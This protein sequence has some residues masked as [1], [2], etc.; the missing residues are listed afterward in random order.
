MTI[1]GRLAE[2]LSAYA[3]TT[4]ERSVFRCTGKTANPLAPSNNGGRWAPQQ[5]DV[6]VLY[7]SLMSDGAVAEK[8]AFLLEFTPP[9]RGATLRIATIHVTLRKVV[10]LADDDLVKFGVDPE[11]FGTRDYT[12]TKEIGAAVKF[13]GCDGLIA[14][15]ARWSC[16]N[17][18]VYT[19]NLA[20]YDALKLL[21]MH[22]FA[23]G[24]WLAT[25]QAN[26]RL[27]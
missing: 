25:N 2:A 6:S 16:T 10:T 9:P 23:L 19:D 17:L 12:R 4:L 18:M 5:N 1:D 8:A 24:D 15:S 26:L 11:R 22:E 14:P 20:D 13:L 27:H 7:T 21:E 3:T